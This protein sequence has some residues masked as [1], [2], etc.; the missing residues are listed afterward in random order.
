MPLLGSSTGRIF[1]S[2]RRCDSIGIAGRIYDKLVGYFGTSEIY[3]DIDAIPPGVD[4]IKHIN[5]GMHHAQL[6]LAL[7]GT[8]WIH[9]QGAKGRRLDDPN[10]FVR[11]E[12][13][14]ALG[15]SIP[16]VPVLL[17]AAEMPKVEDLPTCLAPLASFNAAHIELGRDFHAHTERLIRHIEGHLN[18][19]QRVPGPL[20][21][22]DNISDI[23]KLYFEECDAV[24]A[25]S[26]EHS[27]SIEPKTELVGFR[28]LINSFRGIEQNDKKERPIIWVLDLGGQ[29]FDDLD[30][31]MKYL[32]AQ[33]LLSRFK[34]LKLFS[35]DDYQARWKWLQSRAI[36]VILDHIQKRPKIFKITHPEF[37]SHNISLST[38]RSEW[39]MSKEFQVLYMK[40]IDSV[41]ERNFSVF[42]KANANWKSPSK[43]DQADLRYFGYA[44]FYASDDKDR[45]EIRGIE[46]PPLPAN[47][48]EAFRTVCAAASHR[49]GLSFRSWPFEPINGREAIQKL[50]YLGYLVLRLDEFVKAY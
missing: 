5:G 27:L 50:R 46:L 40:N 17:G 11:I 15:R 10:D 1:I 25:A 48:T 47:Y 44:R 18:A 7:I 41:R 32:N 20:L 45:I 9:A 38:I 13:E 4:F 22:G 49:L 35:D 33:A 36:I 34:A 6:V 30:S 24:I 2:Y 14:M 26:P 43:F 8:N 37:G 19:D 12:I 29:R 16:I 39:L 23:L 21:P 3:M 28:N 42:F 31:R